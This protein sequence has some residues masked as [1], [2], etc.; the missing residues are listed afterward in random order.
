[1]YGDVVLLPG[2]FGRVL[3]RC[4]AAEVLEEVGGSGRRYE[5]EEGPDG[6]L[7]RINERIP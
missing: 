7:K 1:M 3:G 4:E 2:V 5:D 6:H